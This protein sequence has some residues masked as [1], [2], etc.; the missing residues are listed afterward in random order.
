MIKK[1]EDITENDKLILAI[2]QAGNSCANTL[3]NHSEYLYPEAVEYYE[4]MMTWCK[5]KIEELKCEK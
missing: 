1:F 2:S 5:E 3:I 4:S